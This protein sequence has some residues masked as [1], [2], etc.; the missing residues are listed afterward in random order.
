MIHIGRSA[1]FAGVLL[2]ASGLARPAQAFDLTGAWSTNP[3][4]CSH[5][6]TRKGSEVIFSELSDLYGS[7]FVIDG[8]R[9]QGKAANCTITSQKQNG[10]VITLSAAC[11][12]SIMKQNYEFSVKIVDDNT[13]ARLFP[14][15]PNMAVSY[16]RC[17]P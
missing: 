10:D 7:G 1:A 17:K 13:I 5:I 6:F 12:T 3:E 9:I 14:D 2:L 15:I 16:S 11:A 4:L 8:A